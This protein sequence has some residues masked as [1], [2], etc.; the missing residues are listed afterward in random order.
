MALVDVGSN[1]VAIIEAKGMDI[2]LL[3]HETPAHRKVYYITNKSNV[4]L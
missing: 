3:E 4:L 2:G 1:P